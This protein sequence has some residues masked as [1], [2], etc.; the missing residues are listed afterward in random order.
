MSLRSNSRNSKWL[1]KLNI[2]ASI[3]LERTANIG[4]VKFRRTRKGLEAT[5]TVSERD[6]SSA[7]NV[8][9][10]TVSDVLNILAFISDTPAKLLGVEKATE[11]SAGRYSP[12][13]LRVVTEREIKTC[14]ELEQR[15]DTLLLR[16]L[17]WYRKGNN[18]IDPFDAFLAYW[19]SI[20]IISSSRDGSSIP[21]KVK[22]FATD[23]LIQIN[24]H[25]IDDLYGTRNRITHGGKSHDIEQ[26]EYVA[27]KISTMKKL[28]RDFLQAYIMQH[29]NIFKR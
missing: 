22:N 12:V 3:L 6:K 21:E 28:A 25:E 15:E 14:N 2:E 29:G 5:V 23:F 1:V 26:I 8:A 19:T 16:A 11:S 17:G 24:D 18:E 20:E 27:N 9:I 13:T 10:R 4:D 7:K